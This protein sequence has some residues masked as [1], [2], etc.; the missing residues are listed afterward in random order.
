MRA[1]QD[2]SWAHRA[3][4]GLIV[5]SLVLLL[6]QAVR[7][8]FCVVTVR[9][10]SM[11]P[12][13]SDGDRLIARRCGIARLRR[14]DLVIFREPG[15][16]RPRPAWLT[17]AGADVWVIK[18]VAA[19]A[20]DPVPDCVRP[21]V[22]AA[23]IVPPWTIVVLGDAAES[24]DSREWGFIPASHVLGIGTRTLSHRTERTGAPPAMTIPAASTPAAST[25]AVSA[26]VADRKQAGSVQ[27][28]DQ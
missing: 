25:P 8:L 24:R 21:A 9:G 7:W 26:Q 6:G 19:V 22:G 1:G 15:R 11:E 18:R 5:T 23:T 13:L 27:G 2:R 14:G 28:A 16:N 12:A 10:P 20:G 17:G 3:G 4:W